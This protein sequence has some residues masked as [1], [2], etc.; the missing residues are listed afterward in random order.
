MS[1]TFY[2]YEYDCTGSFDSDGDYLGRS[3]DTI[4]LY[5]F[6]VSKETPCG[7]WIEPDG[8]RLTK[9]KFIKMNA[10]RH[11][12]LWSKEAALD[13]YI[14]RKEKQI[15][16]LQEQIKGLEGSLIVARS[17]LPTDAFQDMLAAAPF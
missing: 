4:R 13:S 14:A 15:R 9:R 11:W 12:A 6:A 1:D 7:V 16:I 2:R 17:R 10:L 5:Q 3:E 8:N